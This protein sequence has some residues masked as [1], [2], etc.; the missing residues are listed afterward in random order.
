MDFA[1]QFLETFGAAFVGVSI[2]LVI[3]WIF[4]DAGL[5][6]VTKSNTILTRL[7]SVIVYSLF[8]VLL[9]SIFKFVYY[10]LFA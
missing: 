7:F 6:L 5:T 9:V 4:N 10:S 3:I 2:G 8:T 1:Y